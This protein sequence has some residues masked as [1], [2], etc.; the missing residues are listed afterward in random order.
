MDGFCLAGR[1]SRHPPSNDEHYHSRTNT[2]LHTL[3]TTIKQSGNRTIKTTHYNTLHTTTH[4][5]QHT[6][7]YT[8]HTTHYTLQHT[9]TLHTTIAHLLRLLQQRLLEELPGDLLHLPPRLLEALVDGDGAHG[10]GGVAHHPLAGVVDV[11]A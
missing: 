3:T 8:L 9:T 10:D 5:T 2:T 11:G 6:T 1:S 4:Y 7:H